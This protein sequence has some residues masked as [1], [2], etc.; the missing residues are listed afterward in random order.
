MDRLTDKLLLETYVNALL[1]ECD[2]DFIKQLLLELNR[3]KIA[4]PAPQT[5]TTATRFPTKE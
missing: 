3:R 2:D 4:I 5:T 1:V